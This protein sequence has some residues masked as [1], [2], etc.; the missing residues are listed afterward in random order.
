MN[1]TEFTR[2]CEVDGFKV[3]RIDRSAG[4]SN[5]MHTHIFSAK[6]MVLKGEF[7]VVL[8][9]SKPS[10]AQATPAKFLLERSTLNGPVQMGLRS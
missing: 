2:S 10:V 9:M 7:T 8:K 5:E 1:E 3:K 6:L 4:M